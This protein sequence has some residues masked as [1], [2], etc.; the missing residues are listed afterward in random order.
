MICIQVDN[1]NQG[2]AEGLRRTLFMGLERPSR[3]G[4]VLVCP[5]PVATTYE[6]PNNRVLFSAARDANPFFHMMEALWM[7]AG[8]NDLEW[9]ALFNSRI[10]QYSDDKLTIH[11]AYGYRWRQYWKFDQIPLIVDELKRDPYSRRAVLAM[12]DAPGDFNALDGLDVPCNTHAYFGIMDGKLNMTVC[13]RSNDIWWGCYGA[14]AVHFSM[15]LEYMAAAI[16]VQVG[17]YVQMSN[18]FHLYTDVVTPGL[19]GAARKERINDLITDITEADR[20]TYHHPRGGVRE[21]V[22]TG[23]K[24]LLRQVPMVMSPGLGGTAAFDADLSKFMADPETPWNEYDE[25]FFAGVVGPMY[26]AWMAYKRKDYHA[27]MQSAE[28]IHAGDWSLACCE[29][30]ERRNRARQERLHAEEQA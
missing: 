11:G 2:L 10:G 30:L 5:E 15:L 12:W 19:E 16:G 13:C 21:K 20:Y 4:P 1:V 25:P 14:N 8:R 26:D 9:P 24:Y 3:N 18:N 22:T 29:W 7:L 17:K 23:S 27:A 6:R 28:Q